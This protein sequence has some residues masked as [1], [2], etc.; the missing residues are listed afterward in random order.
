MIVN[1]YVIWDKVT[2]SAWVFDTG[3]DEQ[4]IF[5]F[6]EEEKL[7]LDA[8]FLT[9]THRDHVSCLDDL[10]KQTRSLKVYVHQLEFFDGC[11][12]IEE[13]FEYSVDSLSMKTKHTHGHSLGGMTYIVDDWQSQSLLSVTLSLG[14]MYGGMVSY[15]VH[16]KQIERK[17]CAFPMILFF[18]GPWTG[19]QLVRKMNNPLPEFIMLPR[20]KA[21]I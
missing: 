3:T 15:S 7:K 17:S 18:V 19:Y 10:C 21:K 11:V 16:C 20:L 6:I 14:S 4:P 1:A 8:I 9:H 2:R 13:G 12:P 5:A